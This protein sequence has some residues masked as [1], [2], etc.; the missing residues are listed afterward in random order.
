VSQENTQDEVNLTF[1]IYATT[2]AEAVEKAQ[3]LVERKIKIL[4]LIKNRVNEAET[5]LI[6]AETVLDMIDTTEEPS[7]EE[8]ASM[9][10][11]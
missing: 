9:A 2:K 4:G 1:N 7:L 5:G 6:L 3:E 11:G 8:F 10:L